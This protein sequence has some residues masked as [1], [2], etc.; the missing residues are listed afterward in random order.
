MY[1]GYTIQGCDSGV[2]LYVQDI[3]R[4]KPP[5]PASIPFI[6]KFLMQYGGGFQDDSLVRQTE[7]FVRVHGHAQRQLGQDF[8]DAI[9]AEARGMNPHALFKH[10]MLKLAS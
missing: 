3:M 4:S 5:N 1:K 7:S 2:H 8:W 10:A 6:F 9:S